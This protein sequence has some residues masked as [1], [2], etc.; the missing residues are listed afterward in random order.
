MSAEAW[1]WRETGSPDG[2]E[3]WHLSAHCKG[4]SRVLAVVVVWSD[5]SAE[6]RLTWTGPWKKTP[7]AA[8]AKAEAEAEI[9]RI[10]GRTTLLDD[11]KFVPVA[12]AGGKTA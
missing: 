6:W 9:D 5:G 3:R 7:D 4:F 10:A 12:G 11:V 2:P 1:E 8:T